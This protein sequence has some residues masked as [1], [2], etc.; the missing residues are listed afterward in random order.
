MFGTLV[1]VSV[2][3][4]ELLM[5]LEINVLLLSSVYAYHS[6][7]VFHIACI[8]TCVSVMYCIHFVIAVSTVA[9]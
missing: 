1:G 5:K 4:A 6:L 8:D 2:F 3:S 9:Q 7:C